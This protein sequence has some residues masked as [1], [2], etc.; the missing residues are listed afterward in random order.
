MLGCAACERRMEFR[1]VQ[2]LIPV[3]EG[4]KSEVFI[5]L[6]KQPIKINAKPPFVTDGHTNIRRGYPDYSREPRR[7]LK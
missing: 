6:R 3:L 2:D 4:G 1:E 7:V 5:K